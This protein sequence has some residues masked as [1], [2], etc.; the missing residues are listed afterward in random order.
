VLL[1]P[2]GQQKNASP[3]VVS[4]IQIPTALPFGTAVNLPDVS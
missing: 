3:V 1:E 4:T 2:L